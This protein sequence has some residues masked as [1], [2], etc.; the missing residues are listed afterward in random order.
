MTILPDV[1]H[2]STTGE[3]TGRKIK[4]GN[5]VFW[6]V[7]SVFISSYILCTSSTAPSAHGTVAFA[8]MF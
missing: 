8:T 6:N 4:P 1:K 3:F 7:H 2:K 5:I